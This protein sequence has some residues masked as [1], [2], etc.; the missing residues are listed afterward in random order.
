MTGLLCHFDFESDNKIFK[1]TSKSQ[2]ANY[3]RDT[4]RFYPQT[5]QQ[6]K[7]QNASQQRTCDL[8]PY[9]FGVTE[10]EMVARP[11]AEDLE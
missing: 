3:S 7:S 6:Q 2:L 5:G 8:L 1:Q 9:R 11:S 10:V 4:H